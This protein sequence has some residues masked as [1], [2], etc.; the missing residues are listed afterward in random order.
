MKHLFI[1]GFEYREVRAVNFKSFK[2]VRFYNFIIVFRIGVVKIMLI[3]NSFSNSVFNK[4]AQSAN[5]LY[6]YK[7]YQNCIN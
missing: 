1:K 7:H 5:N 4:I 6:T 2:V 3:N